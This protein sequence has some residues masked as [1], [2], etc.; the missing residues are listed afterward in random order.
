M[1]SAYS[2]NI[3]LMRV[4]EMACSTG[5]N[6]LGWFHPDASGDWQ[7]NRR[8][9]G[10]RQQMRIP[11]SVPDNMYAEHVVSTESPFFI[12]Y[13]AALTRCGAVTRLD[14]KPGR[15]YEFF[16]N[17]APDVCVPHLFEFEDLGA[18]NVRRIEIPLPQ[19]IEGFLCRG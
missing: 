8:H 3:G 19:P 14:L 6:S 17:I 16:L 2:T 11:A 13:G 4:P 15:E 10:L 18:K 1:L 12:Q 7:R 5:I 9:Y